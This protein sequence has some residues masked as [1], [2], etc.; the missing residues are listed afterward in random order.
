MGVNSGLG[1]VPREL[2]APHSHAS[3]GGREGGQKQVGQ[4]G[5]PGDLNLEEELNFQLLSLP[6]T[7][8]STLKRQIIL[9]SKSH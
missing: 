2:W 7:Q 1:Q 9:A 4:V 6:E 3:L 5:D 8:G